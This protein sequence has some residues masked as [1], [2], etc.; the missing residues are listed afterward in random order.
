[1]VRDVLSEDQMARL[2][3]SRELDCSVGMQGVGRFR[4]NGFYQRGSLAVAMRL[5]PHHIP[6]M[7]ELGLPV[8][9]VRSLCEKQRGMVIVT[10]PTGCGKST[11]L[12]S[13]IDY[14][15]ARFRKH[16]VCIEDPI[17]YLHSHAR[18]I[19]NQRELGQDTLSFAEA[20]RHAH[21]HGHHG[22]EPHHR[23]LPR[24][25]AETGASAAVFRAGGRHRPAVAAG[26]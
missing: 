13:M 26:H 17:E 20:L 16:I 1:M 2:T 21:E 15:N 25:A 4:I 10:G 23:R 8:D 11:T 18:S 7:A 5:L 22:R 3:S 19:V 9:T 24:R 12:A 6:G 14:I